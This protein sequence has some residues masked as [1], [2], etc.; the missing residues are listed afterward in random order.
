M[1]V[2]GLF[3][4][5]IEATLQ[6]LSAADLPHGGFENPQWVKQKHSHAHDFQRR[7]PTV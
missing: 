5:S 4:R 7:A 1:T 6:L 3:P 2:A